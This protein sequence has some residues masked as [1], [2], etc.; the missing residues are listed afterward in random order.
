MDNIEDKGM[1]P[2]RSQNFQHSLVNACNNLNND[3]QV[4]FTTSMIADDLN[5]TPNCIGPYYPKG[6]HTLDF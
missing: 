6:S 4:I 3:Y 2:E 5:N 1:V